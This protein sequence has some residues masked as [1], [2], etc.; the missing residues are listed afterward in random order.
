MLDLVMKV[1]EFKEAMEDI[2]VNLLD[3]GVY[4]SAKPFMPM[5]SLFG[6]HKI[7]YGGGSWKVFGQP[8]SP[9]LMRLDP[10]HHGLPNMH[11]QLGHND[12][13]GRHG[14]EAVD[15]FVSALIGNPF[16]LK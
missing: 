4:F 11:L 2:E 8:S 6:F 9:P 14:N 12:Y 7:D 1:C 10:A 13:F 5:G 15:I 3:Y 16:I